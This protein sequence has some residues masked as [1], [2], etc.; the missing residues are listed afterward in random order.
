MKNKL[1]IN[2]LLFNAR[3]PK[4]YIP[5]NFIFL[6]YLFEYNEN[7]SWATIKFS[8]QLFPC[9]LE[10]VDLKE[11]KIKNREI[12]YAEQLFKRTWVSSSF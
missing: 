11:A 1:V 3:I 2:S 10:W 7:Y 8:T 5:I 6:N 9:I 12:T 4:Y